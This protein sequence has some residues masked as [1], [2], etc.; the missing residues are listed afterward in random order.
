M[1]RFHMKKITAGVIMTLSGVLTTHAFAQ[2]E[3]IKNSALFMMNT[4]SST[5]NTENTEGSKLENI[6]NNNVVQMNSN[7]MNSSTNRIDMSKETVF[8]QGKLIEIGDKTGNLEPLKGFARDLPLLDVLKQITP[9]GWVVKKSANAK[10]LDVKKLVSW[11]GGKSWVDTL[12]EVANKNGLLIIVNWKKSDI[13]ISS[14]ENQIKPS[15]SS[16]VNAT[17]SVVNNEQLNRSQIPEQEV[18]ELE[19]NGTAIA[20]GNSQA[21]VPPI[22][23]PPTFNRPMNPINKRPIDNRI[24]GTYVPPVV[25]TPPPVTNWILDE[26]KSLKENV[27]ELGKKANYKVVW[28][29]EDYPVDETRSISGSFD[30]DSGP[31]KQLSLDYGPK[32]RVKQPLTF[33]FFQNR[34]L[35]VENWKFEQQSFPQYG[36]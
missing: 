32:S 19:K 30:G 26:S 28:L 10:N 33:Q 17:Q 13:T 25:V 9:N 23:I 12:S 35:V 3:E 5:K 18:F 20:V 16:V 31:I 36:Q 2:T 11:T 7:S 6:K 15:V 29:G 8:S 14:F 34:T 4:D 21:G 22:G 27:E 24:V 1:E